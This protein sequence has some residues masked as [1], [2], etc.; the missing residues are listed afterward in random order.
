MEKVRVPKNT[1][2]IALAFSAFIVVLTRA[3]LQSITIDEAET[4]LGS[5]LKPWPTHWWPAADNHVLNTMLERLCIAVF[6]VS[7]LT[8]RLPA[9]LGASIFIASAAY[10]IGALTANTLIR[11][12][13]F[14][15]L[16]YNPM[17]LDYLVAARGY[18][19]ASGCFLAAIAVIAHSQLRSKDRQHHKHLVWVSILLALSCTANFSFSIAAGVTL[20]TYF[21]WVLW[22]HRTDIKELARIA[23]SAFL[24]GLAIGFVLCGSVVLS[25]PKSELCFGAKSLSE[26][27]NSFASGSFDELNPNLINPLLMRWLS[28]TRK[29]LPYVTLAGGLF[30]IAWSEIGG[31]PYRRLKTA[32]EASN[33]TRNFVRLISV[34]SAATLFLHWLAL[35][36]LDIPLPK[37]RTGVFLLPLCMLPICGALATIV[38]FRTGRVVQFFGTATLAL[39]AFYFFGCL[40]LN[41]FREWK[42][43]SDAKTLYWMMNDL[44]RRCHIDKFGI[45]WRYHLA[46]NF[47]REVYQNYELKEFSMSTS[48]ELPADRDAY[49]VFLP[50]SGDFIRQQRLRVIYHSGVSDAAVAIRS[51][52]PPQVNARSPAD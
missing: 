27:W 7:N 49:A 42:F 41:Y 3:C 1:V 2:L 11:V 37:D 28:P 14:I 12:V 17:T 18:S 35:R 44:H 38:Q 30:L 20:I 13:S 34:V 21:F 19:L 9:I 39:V 4:V 10:I 32:Q 8:P 52:P 6:G 46:L 22:P 40:R 26:M 47:Y 24:P 29:M 48:G 36:L 15:C 5:V 25:F 43:D 51:C 33:L 16:V 23:A 45:D 50:T 31:W